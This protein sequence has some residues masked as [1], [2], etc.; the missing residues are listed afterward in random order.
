MPAPEKLQLAPLGEYCQPLIA[1]VSNPALAM[2][3]ALPTP[4]TPSWSM[5]PLTVVAPL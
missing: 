3:T 1:G 4:N 2:V 5:P